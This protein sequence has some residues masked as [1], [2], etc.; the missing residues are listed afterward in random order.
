V[1]GEIEGLLDSE[2]QALS[3]GLSWK[4]KR[5]LVAVVAGLSIAGDM[6]LRKSR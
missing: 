2:S 1:G 5:E 6:L 3:D 4:L